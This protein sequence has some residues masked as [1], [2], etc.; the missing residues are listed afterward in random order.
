VPGRR[1]DLRRADLGEG[2]IAERAASVPA[3][4]PLLRE[5][6]LRLG[7]GIDVLGLQPFDP[8]EAVSLLAAPL[9]I[10]EVIG[11]RLRLTLGEAEGAKP[12]QGVFGPQ[13]R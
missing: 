3:L 12:G 5:Q 7:G 2:E 10:E 13:P 11:E 1:P 8:R 6:S 9:R 4:V